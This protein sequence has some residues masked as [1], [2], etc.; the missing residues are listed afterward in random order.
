MKCFWRAKRREHAF[1]Q[2]T[3][4]RAS[5]F[6]FDGYQNDKSSEMVDDRKDEAISSLQTFILDKINSNALECARDRAASDRQL[7][8]AVGG[9]AML[10]RQTRFNMSTNIRGHSR[11]P[12]S[13]SN[14]IESCF[15]R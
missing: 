3:N 4:N 10:A 9:L 12:E 1:D 11:P 6:I 14:D 13:V 2:M 7:G 8:R 5:R 15:K